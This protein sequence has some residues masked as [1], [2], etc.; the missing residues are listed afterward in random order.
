VPQTAKYWLANLAAN[1]SQVYVSA[2]NPGHVT[3]P[4]A[5]KRYVAAAWAD[6]VITY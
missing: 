6:K 4:K 1:K 5:W 3:I 2:G